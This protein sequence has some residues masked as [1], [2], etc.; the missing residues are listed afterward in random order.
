[1]HAITV[2][3]APFDYLN[4][5]FASIFQMRDWIA[6]SR[7]DLKSD[8]EALF[9]ASA[10]LKLTRDLANGSKHMTLNSYDEDGSASV[11]R[12]FSGSGRIRYVA[13]RPVGNGGNLEALPLADRRIEELRAYIW[14]S[15]GFCNRMRPRRRWT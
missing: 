10:N 13:P 11:A 7:P 6:A 12:K 4:V 8:I 9:K 5:L 3:D 14:S 2:D 15:M 1:V